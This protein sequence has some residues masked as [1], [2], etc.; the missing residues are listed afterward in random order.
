MNIIADEK[1]HDFLSAFRE[2][3][4]R[5]I[6]DITY[7]FLLDD[8]TVTEMLHVGLPSLNSPAQKKVAIYER[9]NNNNSATLRFLKA[10]LAPPC[11]AQEIVSTFF[12]IYTGLFIHDP[13]NIGK[14]LNTDFFGHGVTAADIRLPA[15]TLEWPV[16]YMSIFAD[17]GKAAYDTHVSSQIAQLL[18]PTFKVKNNFHF[19][20]ILLVEQR[21]M[22][23]PSRV[24]LH[25]AIDETLQFLRPII[26]RFQKNIEI[27]VVF[28][29]AFLERPS[30]TLLL[31]ACTTSEGDINF[32][33]V[34]DKLACHIN[35]GGV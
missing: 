12:S 21:Y 32:E 27:K 10:S 31:A 35:G 9:L 4:P 18:S 8:S 25:E 6:R 19:A 34:H 15:L 14:V 16:Q 11:V 7:N 26:P 28:E 1:L 33:L 2:T 20:I 30:K 22:W 23:S 17:P 3:V 13:R 29:Y 5:E 24:E